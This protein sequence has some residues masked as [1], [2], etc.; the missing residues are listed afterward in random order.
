VTHSAL[1]CFARSGLFAVN[2]SSDPPTNANKI[3]K[4]EKISLT[5]RFSEVKRRQGSTTG[6]QLGFVCY[7]QRIPLVIFP[8]VLF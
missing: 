4:I 6:S 7:K 3:F 5:P 1:G 2:P 8:A